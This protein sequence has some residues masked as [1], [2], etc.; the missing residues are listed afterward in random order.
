MDVFRRQSIYDRRL[1][2]R[3]RP[4]DN[5]A[6]P[7]LVC[8]GLEHDS[9]KAPEELFGRENREQVMVERSLPKPSVVGVV[10]HTE[11]TRTLVGRL[12]R[13][14]RDRGRYRPRPHHRGRPGRRLRS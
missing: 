3:A 7:A 10:H 14:L 4:F 13:R 1:R 12:A 5:D 2:D 11:A 6:N 8:P 9:D